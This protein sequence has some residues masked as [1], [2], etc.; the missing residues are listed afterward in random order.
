[1]DST[2]F[3]LVTFIYFTV[4]FDMVSVFMLPKFPYVFNK[5]HPYFLTGLTFVK[6]CLG[7]YFCN[8]I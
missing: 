2:V 8:I 4:F 6:I 1:M 3:T 7:F 5:W